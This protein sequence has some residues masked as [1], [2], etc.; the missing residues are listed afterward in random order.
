YQCCGS[1]PAPPPLPTNDGCPNAQLAYRDRGTVQICTAGSS[2]C[3]PGYFCQFSA[4]NRQFQ[5]CGVSGGCPAESVAF[6]GLSGEPQQ[7]VLGQSKCP[8]GF[9]CRRS[10]AGHHICCTKKKKGWIFSEPSPF[11]S[12]KIQKPAPTRKC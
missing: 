10:V 11:R 5:C 7:C 2:T 3:P 4:S 9:A 6:V 12:P 8:V 1:N